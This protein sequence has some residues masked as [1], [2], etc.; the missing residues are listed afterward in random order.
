MTLKNNFIA[1]FLALFIGCYVMQPTISYAESCN[2]EEI[3]EIEKDLNENAK[4]ALQATVEALNKYN[5]L[6][7]QFLSCGGD[8]TI[9]TPSYWS[10]EALLAANEVDASAASSLGNPKDYKYTGVVWT[11][12][13][14]A[15]CKSIAQQAS[16]QL[17]TY[18]KAKAQTSAF[19]G[20]IKGKN[21]V[22]KA[23]LCSDDGENQ[24]CLAYAK[25]NN[26][27]PAE[28][29]D[30][31]RTFSEYMANLATC[32]L[33]SIFEV[34]LNTDNRV[35]HVAWETIADPLK[36]IVTVFFA[37]ILAIET[38]K[39]VGAIAGS[40]ISSYLKTILIQGL[41]VAIALILLSNSSYIYGY[42]V[43]PVIEGGLEMGQVFLQMG[44]DNS[45][46]CQLTG[47]QGNFGDVA[48]G[49]LDA[50]LLSNILTT[51]RCFN[52]SAVI[53]PAVGR[54]LICHGWA[55]DGSLLPDL[56][57]WFSGVV[58]YLFGLMIWLAITF[59]LIDCT[60][61]LGM[62]CALMPLFV[63][64]WPFKMTKRYTTTGAKMI[65]NTFFNY[66]L[67]G[68][69]ILVGLQIITFSLSGGDADSDMRKYIAILNMG[70]PKLDDL[71]KMGSL[72]GE[73]M[74]ILIVCAIMAMKL[75]A[76]ANGAANKFSA[77]SGS[78]IG[79][80]MGGTAMSA[81]H[82]AAAE[83]VRQINP[84]IR[85]TF[86]NNMVHAVA[87]ETQAG[88]TIRSAGNRVVTFGKNIGHGINKAVT[89][90]APAFLGSKLSG[91]YLDKFQ[92]R[93]TQGGGNKAPEQLND[94]AQDALDNLTDD[95]NTPDTPEPPETPETPELPETPETS[96][97]PE[98]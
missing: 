11:S 14:P 43:S 26:S 87:N 49:E 1:L 5:A 82:K 61:Q 24:E 25:E 69:V 45:G 65:L 4:K 47:S 35:A 54:A 51:V 42:F 77:G 12:A 72:D 60:V 88:R 67:M 10:G 38:L 50:S 75:I 29:E 7:Q 18:N 68:V 64:C 57:M 94:K 21:D 2:E 3:Q 84:F 76:I 13:S 96:E 70:N 39:A 89:Q 48:G 97:T 6:V 86:A 36:N 15:K 80:K 31:C 95:N 73:G 37:V 8:A 40:S 17:E 79:A 53:M 44:S 20:V 23:C 59:Y 9:G 28:T 46:A 85:G 56:S 32:P 83:P 91:G 90:T 81:V 58:M 98:Q 92:E 34:I 41:K 63:A 93:G 66:V 30:G 78:S 74:L 27:V 19:L 71:R 16:A 22:P 62:V 52:N 33:C 55:N